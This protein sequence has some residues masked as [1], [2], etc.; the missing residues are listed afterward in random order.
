[1]KQCFQNYL[2]LL[3]FFSLVLLGFCLLLKNAAFFFVFFHLGSIG[4]GL[5]TLKK[6]KK[7]VKGE[8]EFRIGEIMSA[9]NILLFINLVSFIFQG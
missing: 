6:E 3:R 9:T 8:R 2:S 1:M 7:I 4:F 5:L